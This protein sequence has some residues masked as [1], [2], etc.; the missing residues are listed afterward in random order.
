MSEENLSVPEVV[1]KA[2]TTSEGKTVDI[3]VDHEELPGV[4]LEM[5]RWWS[6][7]ITTSGRYRMWHPKDHVSFEWEIP[8]GTDPSIKSIQRAEEAMGD[9]PAGVLRI[10]YEDPKNLDIPTVYDIVAAGCQL[11]PN[12]EPVSWMCHEFQDTP[13]GLKI[14]S[15]FR[16]PADI[17]K[18]FV[19][20]LRKHSEEENAQLASFLPE[21]YRRN[22]GQEG[23]ND[24]TQEV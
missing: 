15:T 3:V 19:D 5:T 12:D 18:K 14:R 4:T 11:G 16:L 17:P 24:Q 2:Y 10:R 7:N 22:V 8:P 20:A 21:L 23:A 13:K 9:I 1:E 6:D